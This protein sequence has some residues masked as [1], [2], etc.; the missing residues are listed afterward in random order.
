MTPKFI[1]IVACFAVALLS[2][3]FCNSKKDWAWLT[4]GL[5][6]TVGADY[7]LV[8]N[9]NHLPGVAVFCFAHVCYILRGLDASARAKKIALLAVPFVA[10]FVFFAYRNDRLLLLAGTYAALFLV[11]IGVN[12]WHFWQKNTPLPKL[13]K[14]LVLAG[15]ILFVLCDINVALFNMPREFGTPVV[16]PWAFRLIWVFY[17]PSQL[18]L[19]VSGI[20][21]PK[22]K[23]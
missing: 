16:F 23:E 9:N 17:L 6:F 5:M 13:N 19:A 11:N 14:A 2:Y 12:T 10:L 21:F 7:F 18:L 3:F 4:A 20:A 22:A 1:F 15:L 8:L